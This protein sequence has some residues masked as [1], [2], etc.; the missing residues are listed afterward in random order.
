MRDGLLTGQLLRKLR[1]EH[2]YTIQCI[3][4]LLSISKAAVSKWESGNDISVEHLYELSKFYN[5][6]FDDLY[7]GKLNSENNT[8]FVKRN[9]DLSFFDLKSAVDSGDTETIKLFFNRCNLVKERFFK[10][11]PLWANKELS[12]I[13]KVE[14]GFLKQYFKFDV[15]YYVKK[16][17]KSI[18]NSSEQEK[19]KF[20]TEILNEVQDQDDDA[21]RWELSKLYDF[22]FDDQRKRIIDGHN[23][24]AF[25]CMLTSF[26]QIEKDKLLYNYRKA[27][28]LKEG[29]D[30]FVKVLV[31][32][33]A[34]VLY[35]YKSQSSLIE[36]EMLKA[37][38]GPVVEI[39]NSIN[40]RY[41]FYNFAGQKIIP[42]L[43]NWKAFSYQDYLEFVDKKNTEW[44]A[45]IVNLRNSN[46]LLYFEKMV[47]RNTLS[48]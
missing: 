11:L 33:G 5:V 31:N 19:S 36:S 23:L 26:P 47:K 35:D 24:K 43:D 38:D 28:S 30:P 13:E 44:I 18:I 46:P 22:N 16:N 7:Y 29:I 21:Y 1:N 41:L 25:E 27:A 9:Y 34:N 48:I 15:H 14:F 10:L 45:D 39:S 8:D 2:N 3:A 32:S 12:D 4:D 17:T 6:S 20:V 40:D 37:A 42:I